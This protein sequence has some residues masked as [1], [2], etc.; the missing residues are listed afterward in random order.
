MQ[1]ISVK[2]LPSLQPSVRLTADSRL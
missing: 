1:I 2:K